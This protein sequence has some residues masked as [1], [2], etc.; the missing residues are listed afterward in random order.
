MFAPAAGR[1]RTKDK[2]DRATVEQVL[3]PRTRMILYQLMD[4][5]YFSEINGSVSMGK[6][7]EESKMVVQKVAANG[8]S[9]TAGEN[10]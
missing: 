3:D 1:I 7:R 4:R 10:E 2:K 6:V 8:Q 9:R 5:E